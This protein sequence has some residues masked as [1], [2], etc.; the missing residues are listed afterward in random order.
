M[1]K[2]E[3]ISFGFSF[4]F[5]FFFSQE[6]HNRS[7][8]RE[9]E[10]EEKEDKEFATGNTRQNKVMVQ[11]KLDSKTKTKQM[12]ILCKRSHYPQLR[13]KIAASSYITNKIQKGPYTMTNNSMASLLLYLSKKYNQPPTPSKNGARERG[14]RSKK[15]PPKEEPFFYE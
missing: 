9:S 1:H 15:N 12:M 6:V 3:T 13:H 4:F 14:K 7:D 10:G 11:C 8:K 5:L 2:T